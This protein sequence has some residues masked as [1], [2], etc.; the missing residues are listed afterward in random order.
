M[1]TVILVPYPPVLSNYLL[2]SK[3]YCHVMTSANYQVH[4]YYI[5]TYCSFS[6]TII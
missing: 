6:T 5:D 2:L 1:H 4:A 3:I